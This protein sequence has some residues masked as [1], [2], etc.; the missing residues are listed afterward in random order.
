MRHASNVPWHPDKAPNYAA[1]E[2]VSPGRV[3]RYGLPTR[4]TETVL[5]GDGDVQCETL[6]DT[7]SPLWAVC[8]L[9]AAFAVRR[10]PPQ[11]LM[12]T[13]TARDAADAARAAFHASFQKQRSPRLVTNVVDAMNA[14][15]ASKIFTL[16][17]WQVAIEA[18]KE[19]WRSPPSIIATPAP[20]THARDERSCSPQSPHMSPPVLSEYEHDRLANI[21]RNAD[22][23]R[24]LGL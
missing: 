1:L 15:D 5:L 24:S 7:A 21:A 20:S 17:P 23:M 4:N 10:A 6:W 9:A 8:S 14:R 3:A 2:F 12:L 16:S 22:M 11:L 18:G 19:L 13:V